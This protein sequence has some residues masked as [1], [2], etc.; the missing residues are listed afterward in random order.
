MMAH[1]KCPLSPLGYNIEG[2]TRWLVIAIFAMCLPAVQAQGTA[3]IS[4][5]VSDPSG[6]DI[7]AAEIALTLPGETKAVATTHTGRNGVFS[8]SG[9]HAG[10]Y[11]ICF[12]SSG[13][14]RLCESS[15]T[16]Q[17]GANELGNIRLRVGASHSG[18][19]RV[20]PGPPTEAT[21]ATLY[22]TPV[23][24]VFAVA[25]GVTLEAAYDTA[26][27]AC[28]L[29]LFGSADDAQVARIFDAAVPR[30]MRGLPLSGGSSCEGFLCSITTQYEHADAIAFSADGVTEPRA[31]IEFRRS[32]CAGVVSKVRLKGVIVWG[33]KLAKPP[34]IE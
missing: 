26:G 10:V 6:A 7:P 30:E 32:E 19:I 18:D 5:M 4:G 8:I 20:Q 2:M 17:A 21:L 28:V 14:E 3:G 11:D 1:P 23:N 22:G 13:F 34:T 25:P 29:S 31:R 15:I 24:N 9:L 12:L 16:V 33:P 27:Q